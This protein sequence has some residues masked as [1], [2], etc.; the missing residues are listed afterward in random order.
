MSERTS[1]PTSSENVSST[2]VFVQLRP[3]P[4]SRLAGSPPKVTG[5]DPLSEYAR[6]FVRSVPRSPLCSSTWPSGSSA[7]LVRTVRRPWPLRSPARVSVMREPFAGRKSRPPTRTQL[8]ACQ[9]LPS[10][11]R[12]GDHTSRPTTVSL[13]MHPAPEGGGASPPVH[14]APPEPP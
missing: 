6:C 13:V 8:R 5:L 3:T 14:G 1:A 4:A 10:R 7:P 2:P 9:R 11:L 12:Q